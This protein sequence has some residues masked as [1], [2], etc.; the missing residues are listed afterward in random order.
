MNVRGKSDGCRDGPSPLTS[1]ATGRD[2]KPPWLRDICRLQSG[3]PKVTSE[4]PHPT[5]LRC[6][7]ARAGSANARR[8]RLLQPPRN[9]TL[10]GG[11]ALAALKTG[12]EEPAAGF[13]RRK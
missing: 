10:T 9:G 5:A 4:E 13:V 7:L 8:R 1:P 2:P 12:S 6:L 3:R 11:H